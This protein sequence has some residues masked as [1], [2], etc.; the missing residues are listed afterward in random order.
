MSVAIAIGAV[1]AGVQFVKKLFPAIAGTAA[2]VVV[3]LFSAGAT[4]YKFISEGLPITIS[5]LVFFIEVVVGA[6]GA[7][8]LIKTASGTDTK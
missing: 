2:V 7:Y 3:V 8:S 5:A 4:A 6:I 1:M